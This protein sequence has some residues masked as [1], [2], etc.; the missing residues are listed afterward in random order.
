VRT[1]EFKGKVGLEAVRGVKTV[2]EIAQEY[3]VHPVL[4]CQRKKEILDNAAPLFD[5]RRGLKLVDESS[6]ED[7]LYREI[8]RLK[9]QVD[10]LKK[11]RGLP[12]A[13]RSHWI[14]REDK[15]PLAMQCE[16]AGVPRSSGH[17]LMEAVCRRQLAD[18][19]ELKLRALIDEEY[20]KHPFYGSRRMVV[21]L[22]NG[23]HVVDRK[24]VPRLMR[25]MGL[26]GKAPGKEHCA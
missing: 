26:A 11:N 9:M 1:A 24:R 8:G 12:Q 14:E 23:S 25:S 7:K 22:R 18:A 2:T 4:V 6:P 5:A 3:G 21:F 19:E 16:L 17:T 15:V 13:E 20:T 10:R